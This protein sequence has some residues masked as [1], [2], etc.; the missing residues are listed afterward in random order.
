MWLY[1]GCNLTHY[2]IIRKCIQRKIQSNKKMTKRAYITKLPELPCLSDK[3]IYTLGG[4]GRREKRPFGEGKCKKLSEK[5]VLANK[6]VIANFYWLRMK[7]GQCEMNR[8]QTQNNTNQ[9]N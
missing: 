5:F 3:Y 6:L 7:K 4:E 2:K 1:I 9:I 8:N